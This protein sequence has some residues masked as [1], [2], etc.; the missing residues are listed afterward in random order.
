MV[1]KITKQ[2][3]SFHNILH[4]AKKNQQK[5]FN[6]HRKKKIDVEVKLAAH[7]I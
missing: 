7:I 2:I 6:Y 5:N 1:S 4:A 3:I